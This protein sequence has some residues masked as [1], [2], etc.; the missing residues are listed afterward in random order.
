MIRPPAVTCGAK[1]RPPSAMDIPLRLRVLAALAGVN[2]R[3]FAGGWANGVMRW[4][5]SC[6][7]GRGLTATAGVSDNPFPLGSIAR[8]ASAAAVVFCANLDEPFHET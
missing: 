2:A 3:D 8:A 5:E 6:A 4:R 7:N 1:R